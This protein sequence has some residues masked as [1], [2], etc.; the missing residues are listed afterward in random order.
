MPTFMATDSWFFAGWG[1]QFLHDGPFQNLPWRPPGLQEGLH[2]KGHQHPQGP[3]NK[4]DHWGSQ[5]PDGTGLRNPHQHQ[6]ER[7]SNNIPKQKRRILC[8][9]GEMGKVV[10]SN[11]LLMM[12][13]FWPWPHTTH[14]FIFNF[15]FIVVWK[16]ALYVVCWYS[17]ISFDNDLKV[18]NS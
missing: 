14:I 16:L 7:N 9:S 8:P 11:I 13:N 1:A 15:N 3:P 10:S 12:D 5:N 18:L 6:V 17:L 4:T 2:D